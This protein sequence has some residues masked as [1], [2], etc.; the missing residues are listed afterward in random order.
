VALHRGWL[1]EPLYEM[2]LGLDG[3]AS[4]EW[5]DRPSAGAASKAG[6]APKRRRRRKLVLDGDRLEL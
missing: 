4:V 2:L 1:A 6:A 5:N 3:V